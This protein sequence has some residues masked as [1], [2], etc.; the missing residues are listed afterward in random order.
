MNKKQ[1]SRI[2]QDRYL[3][4]E[5][6]NLHFLTFERAHKNK[7]KFDI[8]ENI[9]FLNRYLI[10]LD[11]YILEKDLKNA[12]KVQ[13]CLD[14]AYFHLGLIKPLY[15][16]WGSAKG[17]RVN[18]KKEG[19]QIAIE[20]NLIQSR[21]KTATGLWSYFEKTYSKNDPYTTPDFNYQVW[22]YRDIVDNRRNGGSLIQESFK[23]K[24]S[25]IGFKGFERYFYAVKQKMSPDQ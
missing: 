4:E 6:A 20:K 21:I 17:G 7:G 14:Q 24:E 22:F 15:W 18:K 2:S 3:S 23:G 19:I 9:V 11:K 1:T 16:R 13:V 8:Y 25:S 5:L 12:L 10:L